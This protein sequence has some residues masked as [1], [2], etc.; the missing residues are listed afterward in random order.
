MTLS[1]IKPPLNRSIL[2]S[3][4][5]AL[6]IIAFCTFFASAML[7][8]NRENYLVTNPADPTY[9]WSAHSVQVAEQRFPA[10]DGSNT[11]IKVTSQGPDG[12]LVL[13]GINVPWGDLTYSVYV[14]SDTQLTLKVILHPGQET[15]ARVTNEWQ[16][17]IV[18]SKY[19]SGEKVM[20]LVGGGGTFTKGETVYVSWPQLNAGNIAK[21]HVA[22]YSQEISALEKTT[23]F[24]NLRAYQVQLLWIGSLALVLFLAFY[25]ANLFKRTIERLK[26]SFNEN[27][28]HIRTIFV[29][30]TITLVTLL[31]LEFFAF[32]ALVFI[33][34]PN[35]LDSTQ[36]AA[37]QIWSKA[38]IWPVRQKINLAMVDRSTTFFPLT[39]IRRITSGD[40]LIPPYRI[41]K[42][43]LIDN[44]GPSDATDAT[45]E[46]PAGMIRVILYGGSTA[47]GIGAQDGTQ[48]ITAQLERM[49]N[50]SAKAGVVFQVLNFGHGG[51]MTYSDLSFMTSM[52]TYLE[53]DI[54]IS[55]N[56]FN[57]AFFATES[58]KLYGANPYVINW[59]DFSYFYHNLVN[60]PVQQGHVALPLLPFSSALF[61]TMSKQAAVTKNNLFANMPARLVTEHLDKKNPLRDRLLLENLRFTASYFINR[62]RIFLSYLQ[63]HPMQFRNLKPDSNDQSEYFLIEQSIIRLS[64]WPNNIYRTKMISQF[65]GYRKRYV[66]LSDE[67]VK[68]PNI[69]FFDIRSLFEDMLEP[70]YID[71][72]HYSPASQKRL[73]ERMF[74][75]LKKFNIVQKNLN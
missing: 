50:E 24:L 66:E 67:Y 29:Y 63:P 73:A 58:A 70:A 62:D 7:T 40:D 18:T 68:Y 17:F 44:E 56:G 22:N 57:D 4:R 19:V 61:N 46:K 20:A 55:L 13:Y 36:S 64:R 39:Q 75:D 12:H 10:P 31:L 37:N 6:A 47:M 14:R 43:G 2:R 49:L 3:I 28:W 69:R 60:E 25:S 30:F 59:T 32:V 16:R 27:R 65:E 38:E 26:Q 48:T 15:T 1:K 41:N 21:P 34:K 35:H 51:S 74:S 33:E 8:L 53:P 52:G 5:L 71:I 9:G 45:P 54:S 42:L 72:I 11:A 23:T